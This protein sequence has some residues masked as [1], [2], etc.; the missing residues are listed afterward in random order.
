[1]LCIITL[2]CNFIYMVYR[3]FCCHVCRR[4]QSFFNKKSKKCYISFFNIKNN[5]N[6]DDYDKKIHPSYTYERLLKCTFHKEI[7]NLNQYL[8]SILTK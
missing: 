4:F 3:Y 6:N 1:M 7:D 8:T 2:K 5:N